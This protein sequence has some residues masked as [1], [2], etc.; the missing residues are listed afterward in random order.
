MY[1]HP[2]WT[3]DR[4]RPSRRRGLAPSGPQDGLQARR[5]RP[6]ERDAR[7]TRT[8]IFPRWGRT[9]ARAKARARSGGGKPSL[10]Q[11]Q[12]A[13]AKA[14][15]PGRIP[16]EQGNVCPIV[17]CRRP[18]PQRSL[19]LALRLATPS[20]NR[21]LRVG[22]RSPACKVTQWPV[23]ARKTH[24]PPGRREPAEPSCYGCPAAST[25]WGATSTPLWAASNFRLPPAKGKVRDRHDFL[26]PRIFVMHDAI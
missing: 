15:A 20:R 23:R 3:N 4:A 26:R 17:P 13:R 5:S 12:R 24:P 10:A 9:A 22:M 7:Q 1:F 8:G 6:S 19:W 16:Q 14:R 21:T 18:S 2:A 25:A 11:A